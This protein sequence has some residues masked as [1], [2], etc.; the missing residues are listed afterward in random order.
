MFTFKDCISTTPILRFVY[1]NLELSSSIGR[2]EALQIHFIKET[3]VLE[4]CFNEIENVLIWQKAND[5]HLQKVKQLLSAIQDIFSTI[6]RLKNNDALDDI[7]LF[8]LKKSALIM[9]DLSQILTSTSFTLFTLHDVSEV[10]A[11]LDPEKTR[12]PHFYIYSSYSKELTALRSKS[13]RAGSPEEKED[14]LWQIAKMENEIR[15]GLVK[16][17]TPYTAFLEQNLQFIAKLDL[18]LAKAELALEWNCCKP[19]IS[20]TEISYVGLFHPVVLH[21]LKKEN[22]EFQ[23]VNIALKQEPC[24]ITGANMTGKSIFLRAIAFSQWMFQFGFYVPAQK[25]SLLPVEKIHFIAGD[26]DTEHTGLSSFV[27]E[28]FHIHHILQEVK[29]DKKMLILVDEFARTTNPKEGSALVTAFLEMMNHKKTICLVT[30]HYS[31]VEGKFR[32]LR[33]KGIQWDKIEHIK[34]NSHELNKFI[35]YQ[36]EDCNE[37]TAPEEAVKIAE[38]LAIDEAFISLVKKYL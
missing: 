33:V 26:S 7:E 10:I 11:I 1:D 22:A 4:N 35:D 18:L 30:T 34:T 9:H 15:E 32:R 28:I 3:S 23:P 2:K 36:L 21:R 25:A 12:L 16:K 37:K 31:N 14:L 20:E 17:L 6:S 29:E 5:V 27:N 19:E 13:E 24:L 38:I 8:E